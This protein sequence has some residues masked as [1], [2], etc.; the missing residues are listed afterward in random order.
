[1]KTSF[2]LTLAV[3]PLALAGTALA[4]TA[5]T[6]DLTPRRGPGGPGGHGGPGGRGHPIV[7]VID[8]D[9]NHELSA[10]EIA[11]AAVV[12]RALDTDNNGTVSAD[13]LRPAR[14]ANAPARPAPP[15]DAPARARPVDPVMLALDAN[16]D[17]ALGAA[18]ITNA[19]TSLL[20]LDANKDGKLTADEFRPLP[21]EGAPE[22]RGPRGP[23]GPR[24]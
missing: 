3:L 10:A 1:M 19:G 5:P 23:R 8:T 7:R 13:E 14:P 15:A 12:L 22:T 6:T 24:S 20:A 21:P 11:N 16:S 9:K 4:Q 2:K 18:E 17:G